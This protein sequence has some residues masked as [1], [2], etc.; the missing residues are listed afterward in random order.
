MFLKI[1]I[2]KND[3]NNIIYS[4]IDVIRIIQPRDNFHLFVIISPSLSKCSLRQ[5]D[6]L[7]GHE[8]Q[9]AVLV[10]HCV[11]VLNPLGINLRISIDPINMA[12]LEL[13]ILTRIEQIIRYLKQSSQ[14]HRRSTI[15]IPWATCWKSSCIKKLLHMIA[16]VPFYL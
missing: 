11:Q 6:N 10:K 13:K 12:K 15:S 1:K 3:I 5:L 9:F 16:Q 8:T 2:I 7:A 4:T 14:G